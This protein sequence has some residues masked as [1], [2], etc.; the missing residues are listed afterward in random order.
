VQVA[1]QHIAQS[2]EVRKM[3]FS[4]QAPMSGVIGMQVDRLVDELIERGAV[5]AKP[6]ARAEAPKNVA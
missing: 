1:R 2:A 4:G 5:P 3:S 6:A